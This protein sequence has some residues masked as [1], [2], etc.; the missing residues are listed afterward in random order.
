LRLQVK[1]QKAKVRS[2]DA[3]RHSKSKLKGQESRPEDQGKEKDAGR[4]PWQISKLEVRNRPKRAVKWPSSLVNLCN[5]L[6]LWLKASLFIRHSYFV[7]LPWRLDGSTWDSGDR[8]I[9]A[10]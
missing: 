3:E 4:Q 2:K 9:R 10:D 5:L 1:A 8:R 6:N 7:I